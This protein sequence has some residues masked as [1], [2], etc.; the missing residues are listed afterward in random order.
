MTISDAQHEVIERSEIAAEKILE[1]VMK[2]ERWS[3]RVRDELAEALRAFHSEEMR[4]RR[5][6]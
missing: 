6:R 2:R 4:M 5:L 1:R 3:V